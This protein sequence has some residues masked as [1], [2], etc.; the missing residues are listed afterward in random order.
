MAEAEGV[1]V[2]CREGA[3]QEATFDGNALSWTK[4]ESG[5]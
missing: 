3:D 2:T 1:I 5:G 4:A